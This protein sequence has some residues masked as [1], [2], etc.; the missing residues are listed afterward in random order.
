M[1]NCKR[2]KC[3]LTLEVTTSGANVSLPESNRLRNSK[4]VGIEVPRVNA[5]TLYSP[6]GAVLAA[7]T[8]TA[9]SY[10]NVVNANGTQLC[11]QI[12]L[13]HLMRD[14]NAPDPFPVNWTEIDPTQCSIQ[15]GTSAAG[16]NAAHSILLTFWLDCDNCGVPD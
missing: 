1:C 4:I 15:V 5:A 11:P 2:Y 7:D 3:S 8:V 6:T 10:L 14:F 12:P 16:Y 13:T 9:S